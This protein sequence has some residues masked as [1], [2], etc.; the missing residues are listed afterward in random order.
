MTSNGEFLEFIED[1]GYNNEN[2]WTEEGGTGE[3]LSRLRCLCFGVSMKRI[4]STT[5]SRRD[6]YAMELAVEVNYLEA[7]AF[8]TGKV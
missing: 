4:L 5:C 8:V 7:K 3:I 1:G 2:Y 6:S